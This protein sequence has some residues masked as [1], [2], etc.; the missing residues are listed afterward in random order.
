MFKVCVCV[1]P[2]FEGDYEV[3]KKLLGPLAL[4]LQAVVSWLMWMLVFKL[5]ISKNIC[6]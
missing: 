6:S 1:Y 5:I 4:Q 3:Q 2:C